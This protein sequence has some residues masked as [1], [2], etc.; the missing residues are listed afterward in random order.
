L[1][2]VPKGVRSEACAVTGFDKILSGNQPRQMKSEMILET[3]VSFI[4]LTRL[5][6]RED[7]I[8]CLRGL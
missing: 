2:A 8:M 1:Q 7:F 5:I 4:H 6:A 3:S